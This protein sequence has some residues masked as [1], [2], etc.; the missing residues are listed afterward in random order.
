MRQM[1]ISQMMVRRMAY[2]SMTLY[3]NLGKNTIAESKGIEDD[4]KQ[5][6]K[7]HV[8]H[9]ESALI[10]EKLYLHMILRLTSHICTW[11]LLRSQFAHNLTRHVMTL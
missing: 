9:S 6:L 8:V 5:R 3:R 7:G 4:P 11:M 2:Q 10:L 1:Y